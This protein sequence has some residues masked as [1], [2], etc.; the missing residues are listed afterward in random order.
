MNNLKKK[1]KKKPAIIK[2][3]EKPEEIFKPSVDDIVRNIS[4]KVYADKVV[5]IGKREG[6]S[7]FVCQNSGLWYGTSKGWEIR[8]RA[9]DDL[10]VDKGQVA[11]G[12]KT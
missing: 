12:E 7:V 3:P 11:S 5:W 1:R 9:K 10:H 6:K 8:K 4:V 2:E